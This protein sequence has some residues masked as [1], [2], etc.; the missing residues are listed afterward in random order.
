MLTLTDDVIDLARVGM[1]RLALIREPVDLGGVIRDAGALV[2][3][4]VEAKRLSLSIDVAEDLPLLNLDRLRIR[5]VLLNLLTNAARFTERGGIAVAAARRGAWVEVSVSDTGKGIAHDEM[6]R[7]FEE[8]Y[9][10]E[11]EPRQRADGIGGVGLGLPLSKRLVELHGGHIGVTSAAGAGAT[12][13]FTL[14]V[15]AP[16]WA[17]APGAP[18]AAAPSRWAPAER[19]LVLAG[20]SQ[21]MTEFLQRHLSGCRLVAAADG[22]RA[23]VMAAELRAAAILV[24]ADTP[25]PDAGEPPPAPIFRLPLPSAARA[26]AALGATTCLVKPVTRAA[27]QAA[28]A[29]LDRPP[30]RIL[31]VDDDARFVRLMTRL[32]RSA[33]GGDACDIRVAHDGRQALDAMAVEPPEL[34]LLDLSMPLLDGRATL[35]AMR[36]APP[37]AEVPVI[38][39]SAQDAVAEQFPV[40]GPLAVEKPDGFGLEE[41]LGIIEA[42]LAAM[43]P[44]RQRL[45]TPAWPDGDPSPAAQQ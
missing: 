36:A 9:H 19:I 41:L 27:L 38:V 17:E 21:P 30:R 40:R 5:Q 3:E 37:L 34:V 32:L 12:F 1:G 11:T 13:W 44:P 33:P 10:G 15:A 24:D 42:L 25:M 6:A 18:V 4:Y 31:V 7:V 14:P 35:A 22:D 2:R 8:F 28:V 26:P 16:S 45:A 23:V 39:V 43:A 29:A 20:A